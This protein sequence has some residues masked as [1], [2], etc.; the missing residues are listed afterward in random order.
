MPLAAQA[1]SSGTRQTT[2]AAAAPAPNTDELE[3]PWVEK[4]RPLVLDEVM[5]NEET[6]ARL[7][8]IARDG[9]M[10]NLIMSGAPG[11]GK[12][13]S[14]MCLANALLGSAVKEAVLELN[15][16][17]DRGIDVVR[18][19]IK[20]FAQKKVTLPPGRHKIVILDEADSMTA[21]AQQALRRTMEL[22][23]STTRFALACNTSNK[24]I[25]PIQSRCAI[26]RFARLSDTQVLSRV[27]TVAQRENVPMTPAGLEAVV[28]CADGDLRLAINHLQAAASAASGMVDAD[29]VF[30]VCDVPHPAQVSAIVQNCAT[31]HVDRALDAIT[32]LTKAGYASLDVVTTLF[33]V[34][35]NAPTQAP[36]AATGGAKAA[37]ALFLPEYLKLEFAKLIGLAHMRIL[38]GVSSN[39]QLAG[40]VAR[41]SRVVVPPEQFVV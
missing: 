40:L 39:V 9:N 12:T 34:V 13:T 32:A 41:M 2:S 7:K 33:R 14:I 24:V 19:R 26:L 28:F 15:A 17:D 27:R 11:I 16:S 8:V 21:G 38:E 36:A 4:Y 31:G 23:S 37:A 18:N 10:P 1:S 22:Y 20:M 29:Q 35:K 5:G 3:L 30:K 6:V 25:E